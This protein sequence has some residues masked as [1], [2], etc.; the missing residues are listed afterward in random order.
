MFQTDSSLK[1][2]GKRKPVPGMLPLH[3]PQQARKAFKNVLLCFQDNTHPPTHSHFS[4]R[5]H[6]FAPP[7]NSAVTSVKSLQFEGEEHTELPLQ[8]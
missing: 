8:G 7:Q 2:N 1:I 5:T 3:F 6:F 4:E